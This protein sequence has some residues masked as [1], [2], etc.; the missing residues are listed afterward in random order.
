MLAELDGVV[1]R[2]KFREYLSATD[3][4]TYVVELARRGEHR[5][6]WPTLRSS[7]LTVSDYLSALV[8]AAGADVLVTGDADLPWIRCVGDGLRA[9]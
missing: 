2:E 4:D 8:W 9:L 6:T 3:V 5:T 7:V 1:R